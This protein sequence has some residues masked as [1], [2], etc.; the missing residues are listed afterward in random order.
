M[1]WRQFLK[2]QHSEGSKESN[3][4]L[5]PALEK[6]LPCLYMEKSLNTISFGRLYVDC[7]WADEDEERVAVPLQFNLHGET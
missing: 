3:F 4:L 2:T 5:N 7:M 1:N 6:N